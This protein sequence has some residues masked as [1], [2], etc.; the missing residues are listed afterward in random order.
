MPRLP[1]SKKKSLDFLRGADP[2]LATAID[3]VG[4][5][6]L[7]LGQLTSPLE[8][9]IRSITFQSVSTKAAT[10]IHGRVVDVIT[11]GDLSR[12]VTPGQVMT[13][14]K[15]KLRD[16][17]LSWA[18]VDAIRDLAR[19]AKKG[20]VPDREQLLLM[21]DDEIIERISSVR[22]VGKWT[23]EMLLIFSLGRPDVL[24][25]TDLGVRKGFARVF[26]LDDLPAPK[27]ILGHGEIW[28]PYRSVASWYLWRAGELPVEIEL[29]LP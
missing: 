2:V 14:G 19:Q 15:Q 7:T 8:A 22:G 6:G 5:F 16:A 24:P 25:A 11:R 1:Y 18:K 28:R 3:A 17:G 29:G 9:L 21:S 13:C 23:V 10:T 27:Q 26:D 12:E 20:I 4:P